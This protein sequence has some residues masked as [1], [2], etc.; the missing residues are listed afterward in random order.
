MDK[1]CPNSSTSGVRSH[2]Q[3]QQAL[4]D[5]H[6]GTLAA[7]NNLAAAHLSAGEPGQAVPLFEQV[8]TACQRLMGEDHPLTTLVRGT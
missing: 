2:L 6:P 7:R 1:C 5:D 8:H 3:S 4:G